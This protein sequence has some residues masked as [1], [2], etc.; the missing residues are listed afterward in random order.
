MPVPRPA[1]AALLGALL[2]TAAACGNSATGTLAPSPSAI[3]TPVPTSAPTATPAPTSTPGP[4]SP[5]EG[6]GGKEA[7]AVVAKLQ[8]DPFVTHLDQVGTVSAGGQDATVEMSADF[9]GDDAR[10]LLTITAIGQA[11]E[12]EIVTIGDKTWVRSGDSAFVTVPGATLGSTM[13]A[14]YKSARLV[15][16]PESLR[17][18]GVET[19]DGQELRHLTAVGTIPYE[20][21][22]GGTGQYDVFDLWTL[23]DGTPV[24]ARTEFSATDAAGNA[25]SGATDFEFSNW[26]GPITIEPPAEPS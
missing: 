20:P 24:I 14:L 9:S 19:I 26:G 15:D 22:S 1:R 10:I 11:N 3:A 8:A 12:Q 25:A 5:P 7:E 23:E 13:E 6:G 17:F 18:V 2:M 16:D 21:S 4:T